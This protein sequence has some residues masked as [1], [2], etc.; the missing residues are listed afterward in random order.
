MPAIGDR[1]FPATNIDSAVD[2]AKKIAV[3]FKGQPF[4]RKA[5]ATALKYK[6]DA[7][8]AFNQILADLRKFG[9]VSG[10]GETLQA[11]DLVQRLAVPRDDSEYATAVVETM[12]SVPL[13]RELY[14]HYQG[15]L[16]TDDD[17][18]ATL[19]NTTKAD[20]IAVQ[21]IVPRI[22]SNLAT[23]WAKGGPYRSGIKAGSASSTPSKTAE[24]PAGS[25][26]VI[27]LTAGTL[28]LRYP[29]TEDG[30]ELMKV[31]FEGDRFWSILLKQAKKST[32]QAADTPP[33]S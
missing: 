7:T 31:N 10:R 23:G 30:I 26:E 8:G 16:P 24:E 21:N 1:D 9:L 3:Q 19:I 32:E 20:R 5:L 12:N 27:T 25:S 33:T 29:L 15:A 22:R 28:H 4:D 18:L 2:S 14:D 17:L 13:F 6:S 11:T